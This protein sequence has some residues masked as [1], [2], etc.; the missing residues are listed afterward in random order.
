[1]HPMSFVCLS[2]EAPA[3]TGSG[4]SIV[5]FNVGVALS[6]AGCSARFLVAGHSPK[7]SPT[8]AEFETHFLNFESSP[9]SELSSW[10]KKMA[11][12]AVWIIGTSSWEYFS[13]LQFDYPHVLYAI[14]ADWEVE[15]IRQRCRKPPVSMV[16]S[17]V[18]LV[19][20]RLCVQRL[21]RRE[22]SM[23][24]Q[25]VQ[26]GIA[27][28]FSAKVASDMYDRTRVKVDSCPLLF[29]DWGIRRLMPSAQDHPRVLLLG[30]MNGAHTRMG[31]QFFLKEIWPAW[32]ACKQ[33]PKSLVRIVGK[34]KLPDHFERPP[35]DPRLQWLGFAPSLDDEWHQALAL[36]TPVPVPHGMRS[37]IIE[38]W[39]RGVP[40]VSHPA[41]EAG[42]PM[43]K[44]RTNY[45]AATDAKEWIEAIRTLEGDGVLCNRLSHE[46]RGTYLQ[47]FS[48]HSTP[49]FL[50]ISKMAIDRFA[51]INNPRV[52]NSS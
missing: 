5:A 48:G 43:M 29:E 21:K 22:V 49:R 3:A 34:G 11:P 4:N 1:M 42:L 27:A 52:S 32:R 31:I 36:V 17:L 30:N 51:S 50:E 15:W 46:G 13:P 37:R 33:P 16:R 12:S 40:V 26:T 35:E 23:L 45:L 18:G 10:L 47:H 6:A 24:R 14:D 25:V 38:A 28:A 8:K 7:D 9:T 19:R 39:C 41:A 44:D 2:K 20:N